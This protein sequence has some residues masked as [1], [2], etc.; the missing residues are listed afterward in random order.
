MDGVPCNIRLDEDRLAALVVVG[1]RL[2]GT[3]EVIAIEDGYRESTES[4][5]TVLRDLKT[6]GM[7]APALAIGDGALG[8]WAEVRE[9]GPETREQRCWVPRIANVLD[10]LPTP[11]SAPGQAGLARDDVCRHPDYLRAGDPAIRP[12]LRQN[13]RRP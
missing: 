10:K 9:V 12:E 5:L 8:F 4:W 13:I 1:V 2:D 11:A 6:R 3:K 7:R